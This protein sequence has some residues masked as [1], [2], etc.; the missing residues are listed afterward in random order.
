M[1]SDADDVRRVL[2]GISG[3]V[4]VDNF[5]LIGAKCRDILHADFSCE[6]PLRMTRDVDLAM[7][8][9][10]LESFAW[11]KE[12][13]S[14]KDRPW[15]E[16]CVDGMRSDVVP[17][18]AVENPPGEVSPVD[19]IRFNV[20]CFKEVFDSAEHRDFGDGLCI[21]V[22]SYPGFAA[23]KLHAWFDRAPGGVYKD[24]SDLALVLTWYES[25]QDL[26]DLFPDDDENFGVVAVMAAWVLGSEIAKTLG[27]EKTAE[28]LQ[29]F[30]Q[31]QGPHLADK[32]FEGRGP[33][34]PLQS[35]IEKVDALQ[36]GLRQGL[37]CE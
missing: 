11:L 33:S 17:F 6:T 22:P 36:D 27:Q 28:L 26:W 37:D 5:M 31:R 10:G 23:L 3:V 30:A 32:L 16:I 34:A 24:A 12:H 8:A 15:Q 19:G 20:S 7:A 13:F 9:Q 29:R 4:D 1:T 18:G 21:R 25:R 35:R 14:T 2:K